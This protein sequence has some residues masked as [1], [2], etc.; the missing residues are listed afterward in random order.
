MTE[1]NQKALSDQQVELRIPAQA[2]YLS[3]VRS[4]VKKTAELYGLS[5]QV[6]DAV[7]LA[8]EEALANVIRHSYCG[9]CDKPIV[10]KVKKLAG[11]RY[12]SKRLEITIRDF[13]KQVDPAS[14]QSRDLDDI[15]PGGLGVHIIR[16]VMDEVEYTCCKDGGMELRMAKNLC[17]SMTASSSP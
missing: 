3:V 1:E 12:D 15:R 11:L 10:I 9:P 7:V 16:S 5:E 2:E 14:I 8:I 4:A 6:I 17:S 13:G